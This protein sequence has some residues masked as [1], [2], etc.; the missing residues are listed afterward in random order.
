MARLKRSSMSDIHVQHN[1]IKRALEHF[2]PNEDSNM[3]SINDDQDD[4]ELIDPSLGKQDTG[5]NTYFR[6]L[7]GTIHI[8]TENP[9]PRSPSPTSPR[10]ALPP[11]ALSEPPQHNDQT[12]KKRAGSP[13]PRPP[14]SAKRPRVADE[15]RVI[16]TN[17]KQL[18]AKIKDILEGHLGSLNLFAGV[19]DAREALAAQLALTE[20]FEAN[21]AG[22]LER[23]SPEALRLARNE[24][25]A[26][27]DKLEANV[28][29][30]ET[31]LSIAMEGLSECFKKTQAL[32]TE[33]ATERDKLKAMDAVR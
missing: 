30:A 12:S 20:D 21:S 27:Q 14:K 9:T 7:N 11:G 15:S 18:E 16:K 13:S 24:A 3:N 31:M 23:L 4:T 8:T 28:K 2:Q 17:I 33:I 5:R 6:I 26:K 1:D 19:W 32:E 10:T 29:Q 25:K 22:P